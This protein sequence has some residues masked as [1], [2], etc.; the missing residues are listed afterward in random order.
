MR[1]P[2]VFFIF[3]ALVLV[4]CRSE[5][6]E[7]ISTEDIRFVKEG[8][9]SVIGPGTT[10]VKARFDIE[11]AE[12]PYETQTGLM[13]RSSMEEQQ[14]ML[15]I[16]PELAVHSFYMKNTEIPLDILFIDGDLKIASIQK[17]TRPFDE[18]GLS[19]QVPIQYVLEINA[20]LSDALDLVPG[21][22]ISYSR[23]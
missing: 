14:G 10:A 9:L 15:F 6:K 12:T 17:N 4:A 3:S 18:R 19:S 23:N 7:A 2:I 8:E 21:D 20:G 5:T 13:Y 11:I 16:F 1:H 22:S